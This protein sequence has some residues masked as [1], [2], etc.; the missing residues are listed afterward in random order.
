MSLE[1]NARSHAR[2]AALP[3]SMARRL[4]S[5]LMLTSLIVVIPPLGEEGAD[6][7]PAS[8][9][10]IELGGHLPEEAGTPADDAGG[11]AA[12]VAPVWVESEPIV[13][14]DAALVGVVAPEGDEIPVEVRTFEEGA[15]TDWVALEYVDEDDGPDP[16]T[17]EAEAAT[18][19]VTDP[20]WVGHVDQL[21]VRVADLEGADSLELHTV[22]IEGSLDF[23]PLATK[24]GAAH[25]STRPTII[26]RSSW[27][28]NNDCAPR[29]T[30][31]V[32]SNVRFTVIHHTA[33][34]NTYTE[35]QAANVLRSICLY[36]RN[37]NGWSDVGY[38]MVVD[39]YGRT[40][41]GRA[42]GLERAVV[43][44][45]AANYNSGSFGIGVMGCFDVSCATSF[46]STALPS[47]A[48]SAVDRA[49]AWKFGLHGVDPNGTIS[50]RNGSGAT[51]TLDTIV[52]H[53]DV[54]RTSCPGSVFYPFVKGSNPMKTRV[55]RLMSAAQPAPAP[56]PSPSPAPSPAPAPAPTTSGD[57]WDE[58]NPG[59][60][61]RTD[62]QDLQTFDESTGQVLV[63]RTT[64]S[65]FIEEAW[66]TYRTRSGWDVHLTGDVTGNG[67][68]DVVSFHPS[69]GSWWV[70]VSTGRRLVAGHWATYG[71]TSGWNWHGL[72]DLDGDG[73]ADLV[74][75]HRN[76]SWFW[77]R[78][79]GS[80]FANPQRITTFG[81]SAGW[82]SH[83]VGNFASRN[84]ES[85]ANYHPS[86]GRW[87]ILRL[88]GST[89]VLEPWATLGSPT[90]WE[91]LVGDF[92]GD[93]LSDVASYHARSGRWWVGR[94]TGRSFVLEHWATFKTN[95]GW[96]DHV[97]GRFSRATR[98]DIMSYHPESGSVWQSRS[99]GSRFRGAQ[100]ARYGT[101]D[102]WT[103]HLA[104]DATGNGLHEFASFHP[105]N[106]SWWLSTPHDALKI[107]RWK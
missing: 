56:S 71:T 59:H 67:R 70:A 44:A 18:D 10:V 48:L 54:G 101:R 12:R 25:A 27:D 60:L 66:A 35:A 38:N 30:P 81:T 20:L 4:V 78:S 33:G 14:G 22:D 49:V 45:H 88:S 19:A 87:T 31:S 21:Q 3:T 28:P 95:R 42:G 65:N 97:V 86:T 6:A 16:D 83:L 26:P 41:E 2:M 106:R 64:G 84:R 32:A 15:W 75:F 51:V 43:G 99:T 23:D 74:S 24:P 107:V 102:G 93:G 7:A 72:A 58:A 89:A 82:Q 63:A 13:A 105:R 91:H 34:N 98:D 103:N 69:N 61:A 11:A 80:T 1:S 46:G 100:I 85:I 40:Y 62:R 55:A 36:H 39:R 5:L 96:T 90:G 104:V 17:A 77:S 53:R 57:P 47:V 92:D 50:Y 76:G 29:S 8:N 9:R 37:T 52:G 73:R 94:S 68:D 79:L